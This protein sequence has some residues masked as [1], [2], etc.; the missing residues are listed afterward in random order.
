M[1]PKV[2]LP[3]KRVPQTSIPLGQ[4]LQDST[5]KTRPTETTETDQET[6]TREKT[7]SVKGTVSTD[8]GSTARDRKQ[9]CAA[10][11]RHFSLRVCHSCTLHPR[12]PVAVPDDP[13][14]DLVRLLQTMLADID[15]TTLDEDCNAT[16]QSK[17]WAQVN[18]VDRMPEEKLYK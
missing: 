12:P 16:G 1:C 11:E 3:R 8:Q 2:H 7:V 18:T 10:F 9:T 5:T 13:T 14:F 15:R 4:A 17:R 6:Q